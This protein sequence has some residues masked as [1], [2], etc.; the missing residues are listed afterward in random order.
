LNSSA[1]DILNRHWNYTSFRPQQEEIINSLNEG[2][3]VLA[4]MPTGGGKSL[5]Y[6][7]P[8]L[9][10]SGLCLVISPLIA[11]MK[12]QVSQ[13]KEMNIPAIALHSGMTT[14]EVKYALQEA[15]H[16]DCK[17]LYV[18]PE[19]LQSKLFKDYL[20][21][22]EI[23]LIAVDEAHCISQW[24][25]D[26]RPSYLQIPEIKKEIEHVPII[27][28]TA[29][30]TPK[31]QTDIIEKLELDSPVV[32]KQSFSRPN[33]SYSF[34]KPESKMHKVADVLKKVNGS[35]IVYCNN[36]KRTKQIAE[37]LQ[38]QNI[39][40]AFYH[41]GLSYEERTERHEQWMKN[42]IR[43]IVCT[44]AFGM[45]INKPDVRTV[46]HYDSPDSLESYYQEAG[47]AG[48]DGKISFAV[49]LADEADLKNLK[50]LPDQRYP[51]IQQIKKIYQALADFLQIPVG[52]GEGIHYEF[53]L[54][55]FTKN[56]EL[57]VT[58]VMNT[59]SILQTE[60][61]ISFNENV[62]IPSKVHFTTD[63][64]HAEQFGILY[65]DADETIKL[66]LRTYAGIF[67]EPVNIYEKQLAKI[68]RRPVTD[69][70]NAL[71]KLHSYGIIQYVPQ[72]ETPQLLFLTDRA[73]SA[74]LNINENIYG[75]RKKI[76]SDR[77]QQMLSYIDEK[78]E[79]RSKFIASYFGEPLKDKCGVCDNCLNR[80]QSISSEEFTQLTKT[81]KQLLQIKP[82]STDELLLEMK[83]G[84]TKG[85]A[86]IAYLISE[87]HIVADTNNNL[88]LK[89]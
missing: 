53:D 14:Q 22:L 26:F 8:A 1:L 32:I 41:A 39:S 69:I 36:R 37:L 48:R 66:L 61:F 86:L 68:A 43:A 40:S 60:G 4:I 3:D 21:A 77:L 76:Y 44:N 9:M 55:E 82:Y 31:V 16:G 70:I 18:S 63:H 38:L 10:K 78:N 28:L 74:Y 87:E 71:Q 64:E 34:L 12:D 75:E 79:C 5:C 65:P 13:L 27:A 49:L 51:S 57:P 23:N 89:N 19:R 73:S 15:T 81:A 25:Y 20:P 54:K 42:E 58:A 7:V 35:A 85:K 84:K 24:G 52:I 6:Q 11:L 83:L 59:L 56:F 45:G 47:R 67:D 50:E 62:F 80:K 72:K 46:I 17:L 30:A 88:H 29:S 2:K 33:L